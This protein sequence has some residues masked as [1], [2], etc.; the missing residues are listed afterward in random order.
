[1][2]YPSYQ[3]A[4]YPQPSYQNA[5]YPQPMPDQLAQLRQNQMQQQMMQPMQPQAQSVQ[6]QPQQ[7]DNG[8][9]IWVQGEAGAK[10][11]LV[12]PGNTVQLWDSENQVIYLK[13]ADMSGMPSMRVL[14]YTERAAAPKPAPVGPQAPQV[15]YVTLEEFNALADRLTALENKP[16]ECASNRRVRKEKE[17]T[18]NG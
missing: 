10:A 4:Y 12:A 5:Y 9:I 18:E 2:A 1:M 15:Q 17:E 16:C 7:A 3:N 8:G 6:T 11:Y 13:S 14:D